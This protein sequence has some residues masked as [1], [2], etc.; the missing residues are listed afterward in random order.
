MLRG[1]PVA[2]HGDGE[3]TRDFC[4]VANVVQANLLAATTTRPARPDQVYN[5]AVGGRTSLNELY[6]T[7]RELLARAPSRRPASRR[8][9]TT[10]SAPGDVRHSQAD[11][12]KARRLLGY[13][14]THD[15]RPG[16]AKRCPGTKRASPPQ[17]RPRT[18]AGRTAHARGGRVD[19]RCAALHRCAGR[20]RWR[21]VAAAA[22]NGARGRRR[23]SRAASRRRWRYEHGEGVPK[24]PLKAAQLYCEAARDGDAEAQF[25]LGWM[26]ANG[27]GV[28]RDDAVAASLFALAAAGRSCAGAARL[29]RFVGENAARCPIACARRSRRRVDDEPVVDDEPDPF[30]DLPPWKQKIA[31]LVATLAP[32][33]ARRAAARARGHRVESNF[34]PRARSVK[35]ARGLMQLIPETAARFNVGN[36]LRRQGQRARRP[37]LPALA[38]RVLPGTG[39]LA[40]AAYNA[41]EAAVDRYRGIPPYRGDARLRAARAAPVPQRAA[42]VRSRASSRPRRSSRRGSRSARMAAI[43]ASHSRAA[44]RVASRA[45]HACLGVRARR[46]A[47]GG[48]RDRHHR[49]RQGARSSRSA[50]SSARARRSSSSAARDSRSATAR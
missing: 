36:P 38:A 44:A 5:V 46:A 4:Y 20:V 12:G 43:A 50:R 23:P 15:V 16:C 22:T 25:S 28:A 10:I 13:E 41:G 34:E 17:S 48:G 24:D 40:A 9:S 39:A 7:L 19:E 14:P 3:T 30:A 35:D 18:H 27:R 21:R 2:I 49:A 8:R 47:G 31:D 37:C 11:I 26:Y 42:S 6:A 1:E 33:Y 29:L 32:R 45:R